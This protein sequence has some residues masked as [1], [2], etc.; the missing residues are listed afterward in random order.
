MKIQHYFYAILLTCIA[1][2]SSAQLDES[3]SGAWAIP[4]QPNSSLVLEVGDNNSG[5]LYWLTYNDQGKQQWFVGIAEQHEYEITVEN[6]LQVTGGRFG[7][8]Q[9]ESDLA[10]N[11]V[12]ALAITFVD[13]HSATIRYS[14]QGIDATEPLQRISGLIHSPCGETS[15]STASHSD[16]SGAW[17]NTSR[18]NELFVVQETSLDETL[19]AWMTTDENGSQ[20]WRTGIGK[21]HKSAIH[22]DEVLESSSGRFSNNSTDAVF[23]IE[24]QL[25]LQINCTQATAVY[26]LGPNTEISG[27][28]T[29]QRISNVKGLG[30]TDES[31]APAVIDDT[32]GIWVSEGFGHAAQITASNIQLFQYTS[33]SCIEIL[34][35]PT[36]ALVLDQIT[37]NGAADRAQFTGLDAVTPVTFS[38]SAVLPQLCQNGGTGFSNNPVTNFNVFAATFSELY[39]TFEHRAVD[40]N[41]LVS[42]YQPEVTASTSDFELFDIMAT[43]ASSLNDSHVNLKSNFAFSRSE[44]I[45]EL[46][47]LYVRALGNDVTNIIEN[48]YLNGQVRYLASGKL[49]FGLLE[50][51]VGYLE[52]FSLNDI[53][54]NFTRSES[55]R[56]WEEDLDEVFQFFFESEASSVIVDVRRNGGGDSKFGL[57]LAS[58]FLKGNKRLIFTESYPIDGSFDVYS[59]PYE[60]Y[61]EPS[62]RPS[63]EGKLI[64]LTSR[65][66]SSAAEILTLGIDAIPRAVLIGQ[67]SHGV[68]SRTERVLLNGWV[69]SITA[70][71]VRTAGG[72]HY[73]VSGIPVDI[74]TSIF[75]Q[76]DIS[77]GKDSALEMALDRLSQSPN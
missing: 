69:V 29:L 70:G 19:I 40:W 10:I 36:S 63:F 58:R 62:E 52:V 56:R 3:H 34:N 27:S 26:E 18:P 68:L 54:S 51:G 55:I 30:C 5:L 13:C 33:Q 43:M 60:Q 71:I 7:I 22:V 25:Q 37:I 65:I 61:I 46:D 77:Q 8:N 64:L 21:R 28:T 67:P 76:S 48:T 24:G 17:Y 42:Q 74:V 31:F 16:L 45:P 6:L 59:E 41:S 9:S 50:D 20:L 47:A 2:H 15:H 57:L 4:S 11:S 39:A 32:Q 38:R 44:I 14:L 35:I 12:G 53:Y 73:E 1:S 23:S 72:A 49:R 66:T 75:E